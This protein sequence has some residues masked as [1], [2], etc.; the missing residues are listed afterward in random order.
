[1]PSVQML[2]LIESGI[3]VSADAL[4]VSIAFCADFA[5]ERALSEHTVI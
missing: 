5:S 4:P 3:P 1:M 2:S